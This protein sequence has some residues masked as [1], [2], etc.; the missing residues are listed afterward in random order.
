MSVSRPATV[1]SSSANSA[2]RA[3]S[4]RSYADV[5]RAASTL[6]IADVANPTSRSLRTAD[7]SVSWATS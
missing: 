3:R 4:A 2:R 7:A 1:R 6:H 5:P